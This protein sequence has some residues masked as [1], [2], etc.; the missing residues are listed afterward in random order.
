VYTSFINP[1]LIYPSG[2]HPSLI[3]PLVSPVHSRYLPSL[4]PHLVQTLGRDLSS[5]SYFQGSGLKF[6][7]YSNVTQVEETEEE[8]EIV[9]T[10]YAGRKLPRNLDLCYYL[11]ADIFHSH[12]ACNERWADGTVE[13]LKKY[14]NELTF[15]A[16]K[17][18]GTNNL[19]LTWKGPYQRHDAN[20]PYPTNPGLDTAYSPGCDAVIFL[21]FNQFKAD[22]LTPVDGHQFSGEN[23][24]GICETKSG[25]GYSIVVDQGY[26]EDVWTGPQILAHHLLRMLIADLPQNSKSC[27]ATTSLLHNALYPG[28]QTVD[29]CTIDKLN[30]SKV[31]LRPCMQD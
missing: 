17:L 4:Y 26:L 19:V 15:E 22:C 9:P 1:G 3:S 31:S 7:P 10:F 14:I 11:G 8:Q 18:L 2:Y 25:S 13:G 23:K 28:V 20:Q 24:G 21:V 16:N 27:P 30:E 5:S 6:Y 29:Q 12:V